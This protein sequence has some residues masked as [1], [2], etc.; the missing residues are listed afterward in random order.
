MLFRLLESEFPGNRRSEGCRQI[1]LPHAT[2]IAQITS[3]VTEQID[4]HS[5]DD[6]CLMTCSRTGI[7]C[8]NKYWSFIHAKETC[9]TLCLTVHRTMKSGSASRNCFTHENCEERLFHQD[10]DPEDKEFKE[11]I[12]NAR[13]K[14]ERS[15]AP[16]MQCKTRTKF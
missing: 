4:S 16:A 8:R 12:K 15:I 1:H 13:K 6:M 14:L 2:S 3:A 9:F 7:L 11:T 10:K 5:T